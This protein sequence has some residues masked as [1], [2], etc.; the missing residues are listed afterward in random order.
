MTDEDWQRIVD[1]LCRDAVGLGCA[2]E[3]IRN[4]MPEETLTAVL[5]LTGELVGVRR[6]LC[7]VMGWD[8]DHD[9]DHEGRAYDFVDEWR[10]MNPHVEQEFRSRKGRRRT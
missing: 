2:V 1:G 4:E 8:P 9:A 10:R 5:A 7:I 3:R 6:A